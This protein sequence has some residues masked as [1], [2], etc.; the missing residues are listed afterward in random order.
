MFTELGTSTKQRV[1]LEQ[2][3]TSKMRTVLWQQEGLQ[4]EQ[5]VFKVVC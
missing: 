2:K 3:P 4:E 1:N 5:F